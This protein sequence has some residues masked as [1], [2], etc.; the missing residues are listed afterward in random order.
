MVDAVVQNLKITTQGS[1]AAYGFR[2]L[3]G[4]TSTTVP[5]VPDG[6]WM[7]ATGVLTALD[8]SGSERRV[9]GVDVQAK[10]DRMGDTITVEGYSGSN[11][12]VSQAVG[13]D[14][15]AH[16]AYE[17]GLTH[18]MLCKANTASTLL[19]SGCT[20]TGTLDQDQ[21]ASAPLSPESNGTYG[22]ITGQDFQWDG[23]PFNH[24]DTARQNPNVYYGGGSSAV[25]SGSILNLPQSINDPTTYNRHEFRSAKSI[26]VS[27]LYYVCPDGL[28]SVPSEYWK[29]LGSC[30]ITFPGAPKYL[31]VLLKGP[32]GAYD[33]VMPAEQG[34]TCAEVMP[35]QT[36]SIESGV[37]VVRQG[38]LAE[39]WQEVPEAVPSA[40]FRSNGG[41]TVNVLFQIMNLGM[42][43][44]TFTARIHS[45]PSG[46]I[47]D[48]VVKEFTGSIGALGKTALSVNV[49]IA[50]AGDSVTLEVIDSNGVTTC[51]KR[52]IQQARPEEYATERRMAAM[53]T[54]RWQTLYSNVNEAL[55]QSTMPGIVKILEVVRQNPVATEQMRQR[56]IAQAILEVVEE[57]EP[58]L[59]DDETLVKSSQL[60]A[61]GNTDVDI[62]ELLQSSTADG[63]N[64]MLQ[65]F[66]TDGYR[67]EDVRDD[68]AM[69]KIFLG[70]VQKLISHAELHAGTAGDGA[71]TKDPHFEEFLDAA[72]AVGNITGIPFEKILHAADLQQSFPDRASAE[73]AMVAALKA[74]FNEGQYGGMFQTENSIAP[75]SVLGAHVGKPASSGAEYTDD[76]ESV[77]L[78]FDFTS[79]D[80]TYDHGN[81]YLIDA[82][83]NQIGG[84]N[85]ALVPGDFRNTLYVDVAMSSIRALFPDGIFHGQVSAKLVLWDKAGNPVTDTSERF[86]LNL[87]GGIFTSELLSARE[88]TPENARKI[89]IENAIL[90]RT[91]APLDLSQHPWRRTLSSPSHSNLSYNAVDLNYGSENADI[92]Q[93]VFAAADGKIVYINESLG[94]IIVEHSSFIV[95]DGQRTTIQWRT[96]Y[97]HMTQLG[98]FTIENIFVSWKVDD[99]IKHGNQLGLTGATGTKY[100]HLHFEIALMN[101]LDEWQSVGLTQWL[102]HF[103]VDEALPSEAEH[104]DL[105]LTD[106]DYI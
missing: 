46:S 91:D 23:V 5:Q 8:L 28:H 55:H 39:G 41:D 62:H 90:Q 33:T 101:V 21:P 25:W 63:Y 82:S 26:T 60:L 78:R 102:N 18:V 37:L 32:G 103:G 34:E 19:V 4:Y 64:Q 80:L 71:I 58:E 40:N 22:Y 75:N 93:P 57:A 36:M 7:Q 92:D 50:N 3:Q 79:S 68:T 72:R 67:A 89:A 97:M 1:N 15:T 77:R 83:G 69:G 10:S 104:I 20:V 31:V 11:K 38:G 105:P 2:A 65:W 88:N 106:E 9:T 76:D 24:I 43:G 86:E 48:P 52:R 73:Q 98:Y 66:D 95:V 84:V 13:A 54:R 12:V 35:N 70:L 74:L 53:S 61:M 59:T 45:G 27:G 14:G 6:T 51:Y 17:G 100:S 16:L 44:G 96:T 30:F 42:Q 99:Q 87:R 56:L 49:G 81:V 47:A 85:A 94:E 29:S